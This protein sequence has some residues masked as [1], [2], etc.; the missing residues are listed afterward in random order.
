MTAALRPNAVRLQGVTS[1]VVTM[2]QRYRQVRAQT[3]ARAAGLSDA[4]CSVQSMPDA[5]P[6]KWHLAHTT[7]FFET[8]VL[9][10][11]RPGL[12]VFD[13]RYAYLFN[14][15]YE[16]QGARQ[17]R[18]A[19][20]MLTRP[21]LENVLRYRAAIDASMEA[22]FADDLPAELL[23]LI[24]LGLQHEQQHQELLWTD[25]LHLFAQNPLRPAVLSTTPAP[26]SPL[27]TSLTPPSPEWIELGEGFYR[28]GQEAAEESFGFDCERPAHTVWL[29][30]CALNSQLVTNRD[31]LA[32]IEAGSY[33]NP[34]L[35]LSDGWHRVCMEGWVAPLYWER[36]E[37]QWWTFTLH[38]FLPVD[39]AAAVTH[40][41]YYEAEAYA[42]WAGFR[43]PTEFEWEAVVRQQAL[44][45]SPLKQCDDTAWQWCASAFLPYPRFKAAAGAVGE[46][47]GKFM[48]G[49]FVLRGG[50]LATPRG[51]SRPSYRNFFYPHQRWQFNGVRLAKDGL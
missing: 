6:V 12:P 13:D 35:W 32:F 42:R 3:V 45:G 27:T 34:S 23:A 14:S 47:N 1:D 29:G 17:P 39:P 15:Y 37:D 19:R 21:A 11:A 46:Y 50:S 7:W 31:W 16:S 25:V 38:G 9:P 26:S 48:S 8:F 10:R 28:I 2:Q 49:Q 18:A 41:S 30:A 5:S 22:C 24:E 36:Q 33:K 43:L 44:V 51:H 4:D 20:G 40:V